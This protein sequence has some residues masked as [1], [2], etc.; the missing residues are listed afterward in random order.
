MENKT[1]RFTVLIDPR[2]KQIFEDI[3]PDLAGM[4]DQG[5]RVFLTGEFGAAYQILGSANLLDWLPLGVVTNQFGTVQFTDSGA[6]N[7]Q[8]RVYRAVGE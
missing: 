3:P 5:F 2:K 7:M 8:Q 4:T 1:A 6:T